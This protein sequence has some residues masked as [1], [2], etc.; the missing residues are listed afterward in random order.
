[1][2]CFGMIEKDKYFVLLKISAPF[3]I[4]YVI[5]LIKLSCKHNLGGLINES[6][7]VLVLIKVVQISGA[8]SIAS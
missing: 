6:I 7:N 8:Q 1:M 2:G 5:D 3:P 4:L